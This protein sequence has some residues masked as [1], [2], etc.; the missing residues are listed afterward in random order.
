M[1]LQDDRTGIPS[2]RLM[3]RLVEWS[4]R[5]FR[6]ALGVGLRMQHTPAGRALALDGPDRSFPARLITGEGSG[7]F[8]FRRVRRKAGAWVDVVARDDRAV[9]YQANSL[10]VDIPRIVTL[11]NVGLPSEYRFWLPRDAVSG[12]GPC[13]SVVL[14]AIV[15]GC[16]CPIPDAEVELYKDG[17]LF[18]TVTTDAT[19]EVEWSWADPIAADI[20]TADWHLVVSAPLYDTLTTATFL[21][22]CGVNTPTID[23]TP[24]SGYRCSPCCPG[25]PEPVSLDWDG[26]ALTSTVPGRWTA[27]TNFDTAGPCAWP[28]SAGEVPDI[29]TNG[30]ITL[31]LTCDRLFVSMFLCVRVGK[32]LI[33]EEPDPETVWRWVDWVRG[34]VAVTRD[35]LAALSLSYAFPDDF[36][37]DF[38]TE[39]RFPIDGTYEWVYTYE[40][41]AE[42][43]TIA[44]IEV[45]S[46]TRPTTLPGTLTTGLLRVIAG[47]PPCTPGDPGIGGPTAGVLIEII[48]SLAVVMGSGT[49]GSDG[50]YSLVVPLGASYTIRLTQGDEVV[51]EDIYLPTGC[52]AEVATT[53]EIPICPGAVTV[54]VQDAGEDHDPLVGALVSVL[55]KTALT[56]SLGQATLALTTREMA[57]FPCVGADPAI[58]GVGLALLADNHLTR[59]IVASVACGTTV[60]SPSVVADPVDLTAIEPKYRRWPSCPDTAGCASPGVNYRGVVPAEL[61]A[62]LTP[63]AKDDGGSWYA[64][65]GSSLSGVEQIYTINDALLVGDYSGYDGPFA[66]PMDSA[67]VLEWEWSGA[68][69]VVIPVTD[70]V[71]AYTLARIF[72][73]REKIVAWLKRSDTTSSF[74]DAI[75]PPNGPVCAVEPGGTPDGKWLEI[76]MGPADPVLAPFDFCMPFAIDQT[77]TITGGAGGND[78]RD[79]I[80]I[81]PN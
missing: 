60:E 1:S 61:L 27:T 68:C 7:P 30:N 76:D 64:L 3:N 26:H 78:Y 65:L 57:F 55:G 56:D 21:L 29:V 8:V 25:I 9:A 70:C 24:V 13:L 19:G 39:R 4:R 33:G 28:Y 59:C 40:Y 45:G 72:I 77:R 42:F 75:V 6:L 37:D 80:Q 58:R 67:P 36:G 14:S 79:R 48:D 49:S 66:I 62:A 69:S 51:E 34:S 11:R 2:A 15:T 31:L 74:P 10:T 23:L 53:I 35:C 22:V 73:R 5:S 47:S 44:I 50:L 41:P 46:P 54:T 38:P 71:G 20:F 43:A 16:G 17:V 81:L 32:A 63:E 12:G 18:D 52:N